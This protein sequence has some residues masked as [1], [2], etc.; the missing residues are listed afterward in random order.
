MT[1]LPDVAEA[2]AATEAVAAVYMPDVSTA[3][4]GFMVAIAMRGAFA[5]HIRLQVDP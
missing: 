2:V 3:P 5:H 4:E 1:R